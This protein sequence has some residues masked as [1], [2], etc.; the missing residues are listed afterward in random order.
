MTLLACRKPPGPGAGLVVRGAEVGLGVRG[1]E[2][3]LGV[4]FQFGLGE[5][6]MAILSNP[7][8]SYNYNN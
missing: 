3:G 2:V 1:A 8:L 4:W 5:A 7:W 6:R